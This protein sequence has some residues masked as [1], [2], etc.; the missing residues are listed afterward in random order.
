MVYSENDLMNMG[1]DAEDAHIA[2]RAED[3]KPRFHKAKSHATN[4]TDEQKKA[5]KEQSQGQTTKED[6]EEDDGDDDEEDDED[7]EMAEWTLRK[8]SAAALDVLASMYGND[9]LQYLL[10]LLKEYLSSPDWRLKECGILALGAIA[11]GCVSGVEP[12][13]RDLVSFLN[14]ALAD[15]KV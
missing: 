12:H 7:D 3:I 2:D 8:C 13:L 15:P 9:I 5:L 4:L 10:P 14:Q 11:E 1:P 6:E